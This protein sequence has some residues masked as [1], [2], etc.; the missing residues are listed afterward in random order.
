[1]DVQLPF[2]LQSF[3]QG[4]ASAVPGHSLSVS[5]HRNDQTIHKFHDPESSHIYQST[6]LNSFQSLC[7]HEVSLHTHLILPAYY[8]YPGFY[9][10]K[11]SQIRGHQ[12]PDISLTDRALPFLLPYWSATQDRILDTKYFQPFLHHFKCRHFLCDKKNRFPFRQSVRNHRG[13]RL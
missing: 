10:R 5:K 11:L 7:A 9:S 2:P 12:F 6:L 13:N 3:F 8:G 1:M 4:C